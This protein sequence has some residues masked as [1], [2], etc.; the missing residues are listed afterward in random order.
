MIYESI[1]KESNSIISSMTIK[2]LLLLSIATSIDA[3]AVGL[4]IY[5]LNISITNLAA[6]T[7]IITFT[8]SFLGI[9]IGN[10]FGNLLKNKVEALGG[11]ILILIGLRIV[12]E[13]LRII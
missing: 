8:L 4:S 2:V 5:T 9:Y 11:I 10:R 12:L 6:T 13:H 7:G 1:K 3:L